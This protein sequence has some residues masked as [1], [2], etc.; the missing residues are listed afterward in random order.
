MT[1]VLGVISTVIGAIG[2]VLAGLFAARAT[3]SAAQVTADAQ[4]QAAEAQRQ[5]AL[6][7]VEPNQRR[8]DL[9]AFNAKADRLDREAQ[10]D[11]E[12]TEE[13]RTQVTRLTALV[14]A[15]A[16]TADRWASQMRNA[17]IEPLPPHPLVDEYNRTGV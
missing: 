11:R 8:A 1:A 13:I 9:E 6:A 15:F 7:A 16:W 14:R 4:R 2:L 10:R 17:R 12:A 5:A 3:K